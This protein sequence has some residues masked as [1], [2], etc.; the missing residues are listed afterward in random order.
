MPNMIVLGS[1]SGYLTVVEIA[2]RG[3]NGFS[4]RCNCDCGNQVRLTA[5]ELLRGRERLAVY[6]VSV[7]MKYMKDSNSDFLLFLEWKR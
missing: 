4:Y 1:R 6:P 5:T 7:G 3:P 2:G